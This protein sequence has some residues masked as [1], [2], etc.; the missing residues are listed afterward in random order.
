[1]NDRWTAAVHAGEVFVAEYRFRHRNG[2]WRWFRE[3]NSPI[4]EPDGSVRYRQSFT[5]D[6]TS[7][8][9]AQAQAER[10]EAR[11]RALVEHL[12][13]IVYVDSDDPEPRSLYVSPNSPT[14]S[15]TRRRNSWPIRTCGSSSMHPDDRRASRPRGH[16]RCL[17]G[18][19][20]R[21]YRDIK[22]DG[23]VV[24]VRDDSILSSTTWGNPAA[25]RA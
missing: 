2:E 25:G 17:E 5:E 24:W 9:F 19:V 21:E 18:P 22:P 23:S 14:S 3:T 8:R 16:G 6:I 12:P 10:S 11:Y 20:P 4:R 13:V 7:E 15:A 1:M